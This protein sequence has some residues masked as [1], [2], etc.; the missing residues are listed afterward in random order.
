MADVYN[1]QYLMTAGPTPLPPA[2]SQVM[3]E[4]ILYHRAPAFIEIYARVLERLKMVFQTRNEVLTF[5]ASGTGALESAVANLI[6]P[7]DVAVVASCGK[8]GQ[9]WAELCDAYGAETVHLEFE[10]GEK[11]DPAEVE[12]A[13]AGRGGEVKGSGWSS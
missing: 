8:F 7:G 3:A 10:W 13:L 11:V 1:K 5:A 12:R 9:R 6:A 2:V 4:P